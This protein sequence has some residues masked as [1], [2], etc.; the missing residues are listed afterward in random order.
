[1]ISSLGVAKVLSRPPI[2]LFKPSSVTPLAKWWGEVCSAGM[3]AP[4]ITGGE[5]VSVLRTIFVSGVA[6]GR[7]PISAGA[8]STAATIVER[9]V[10]KASV[11]AGCI[12][13][14][15]DLRYC[16]YSIQENTEECSKPKIPRV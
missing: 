14:K 1:M 8:R 5:Y 9:M 2:I 11:L 4:E 7:A 6:I 13:W 3:A 15:L 16:D 10:T 12:S